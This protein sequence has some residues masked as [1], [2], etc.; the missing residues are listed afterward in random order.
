MVPSTVCQARQ[1]ACMVVQTSA[2]PI[3]CWGA[4]HPSTKGIGIFNMSY[5]PYIPEI[6]R[7][8]GKEFRSAPMTPTWLPWL[9][10][11]NGDRVQ[12]SDNLALFGDERLDGEKLYYFKIIWLFWLDS[13]QNHQDLHTRCQPWRPQSP[14]PRWGNQQCLH[15]LLGESFWKGPQ[16]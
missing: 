13:P 11:I 16:K 2:Q 9:R 7:V 10:E 12:D 15:R 8:Q 1:P 14:W 5:I 4:W 6:A 3:L